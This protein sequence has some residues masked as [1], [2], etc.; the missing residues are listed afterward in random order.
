MAMLTLERRHDLEECSRKL[1]SYRN[2]A[3]P[4]LPH[5]YPCADLKYVPAYVSGF[6]ARLRWLFPDVFISGLKKAD[7]TTETATYWGSSIA[8]YVPKNAA[9]IMIHAKKAELQQ[10]IKKTQLN[11]ERSQF[12]ITVTLAHELFHV[13]TGFWTGTDRPGTPPDLYGGHH[14]D[15]EAGEAGWWWEIRHMFKG[16]IHFYYDTTDPLGPKQSGIPFMKDHESETFT[17]ISDAYV[18]DIYSKG[19]SDHPKFDATCSPIPKANFRMKNMVGYLNGDY[20]SNASSS[21][22]ARRST[23]ADGSSNSRG[24]FP[25]IKLTPE[26]LS[27]RPKM[28]VAT[29]A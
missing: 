10:R 9:R 28:P 6:L 26:L 15:E 19:K 5:L 27:T 17:R 1:I 16:E 21:R 11:Y 2:N 18:R 13:L 12:H 25:A 24:N 23:R 3:S 4:K 14:G 8:E 29:Q 22:A 7:G 20:S